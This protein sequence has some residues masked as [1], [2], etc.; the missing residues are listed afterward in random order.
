MSLNTVPRAVRTSHNIQKG[1]VRGA[2]RLL[3]GAPSTPERRRPANITSPMKPWKVL[4]HGITHSHDA[5][6]PKLHL[7]RLLHGK[8]GVGDVGVVLEEHRVVE[9]GHGGSLA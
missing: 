2:V 3:S 4:P 6:A 9:A 1:A 8:Q 5:E 7:G